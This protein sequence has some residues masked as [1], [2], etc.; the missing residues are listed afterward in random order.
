MHDDKSLYTVCIIK[1]IYYIIYDMI[2]SYHI[3]GIGTRMKNRHS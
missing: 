2:R 1:E 3:N